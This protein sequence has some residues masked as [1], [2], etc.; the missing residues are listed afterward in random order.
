MSASILG[1]LPDI[2]MKVGLKHRSWEGTHGVVFFLIAT[3][4]FTVLIVSIKYVL[5]LL[6]VNVHGFVLDESNNIDFSQS[7]F[8]FFIIWLSSFIA[9]MSHDVAD[10]ITHSGID[11]GAHHVEGAF[12]S[13]SPVGNF[14]FSILGFGLMA[15]TY[16]YVFLVREFPLLSPAG[17]K[18]FLLILIGIIT[19]TIIGSIFIKRENK[20]PVLYCGD[21]NN[22]RF[23]IVDSE[24]VN[25]K[26]QKICFDK[27]MLSQ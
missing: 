4:L 9:I 1:I 5:Y 27:S 21:K 10:M 15:T 8:E 12:S 18:M 13:S 3:T 11:F 7:Y 2:D 16:I 17:F 19:I 22:I 25:I 24:C 26:G 14:I 20:L 6:N 23:C